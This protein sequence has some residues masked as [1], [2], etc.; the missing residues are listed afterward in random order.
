MRWVW[1][2][3][4]PCASVYCNGHK[5]CTSSR[6]TTRRHATQQV[7]GALMC[8]STVLYRTPTQRAVPISRQY[9][10]YGNAVSQTKTSVRSKVWAVASES[11][12]CF[13]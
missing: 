6:G 2:A 3:A 5:V 11:Y 4:G 13:R 1:K 8:A 7:F 9:T 12:L 10:E